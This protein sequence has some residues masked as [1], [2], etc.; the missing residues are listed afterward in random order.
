MRAVAVP[1]FRASP[2][3]MD[4]PKPSAGPGEAL[5]RI[6][7][8]G[9]NPYD[10]KIADGILE[11]R[12]PHVF[13]LI[14]GVDAA[15]TVEAVGAG[16]TRFRPGDR[17]FGQFLHNP[18][19]T[20][21]YADWAPVPEGIGVAPLPPGLTLEEA[22]A[23]PT[24]GMTALDALE[25]LDL[26]PGSFLAVVGASGGIGSFATELA[27]SRGVRVIAVGRPD[28]ADRLRALGAKEVIDSSSGD[29]KAAL[30][31]AHPE[32]VDGLLDV[33]SDRN[34]FTEWTA[35]V[36]RGGGAVTSVYAANEEVLH[37]SGL[38]GGN[39]DLQPSSELLTRLARAILDHR[40]K[41]PLER[42]IRL[43]EAP[44][45]LA[46]LKAGRGKGKT[47]VDLSA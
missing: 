11:G 28:S 15:G 16:V 44:A 2:E 7:F 19:G 23:L 20:G 4:L 25:R 34:A 27:A 36:R 21:T 43:E 26:A 8:A 29:P 13:P 38:R 17:V 5:V 47:V 18:V 41:V 14:L 32:G 45:Y 40:L 3:L 1:K 24:S 37:R 31:H 39:L 33:M 30:L 9:T 35:T 42:R 6:Q 12:R 46:E 22:A 10:L